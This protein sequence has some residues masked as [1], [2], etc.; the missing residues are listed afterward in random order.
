[1]AP[2]A[3]PARTSR[4][5]GW[6]W[7]W[8]SSS[9]C[10][11]T[12]TFCWD[13]SSFFCRTLSLAKGGAF[14]RKEGVIFF[15]VLSSWPVIQS[16][17]FVSRCTSFSTS[18]AASGTGMS[19][20][21]SSDTTVRTTPS[22]AVPR[23]PKAPTSMR[24]ASARASQAMAEDSACSASWKAASS[25]QKVR[26]TR[27]LGGML[28]SARV[29]RICETRLHIFV[30]QPSAPSSRTRAPE[31]D[32][33]QGLIISDGAADSP[34]GSLCHTASVT[35]GMNGCRSFRETSRA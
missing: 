30:Y 24:S 12:A 21:K 26:G 5:A 16:S 1:M 18:T 25:H 34:R 20:S 14:S 15:S 31:F 10:P 11:A 27:S 8:R 23:P 28:C 35:N 13:S 2:R 17:C 4:R 22:A 3:S 6:P 7:V 33:V 9:S 32:S 29:L 19:T